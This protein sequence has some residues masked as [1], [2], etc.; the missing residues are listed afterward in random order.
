[1]NQTDKNEEPPAQPHGFACSDFG[2]I[3]YRVHS[4]A[5]PIPYRLTETAPHY[6]DLDQ[7]AR[8]AGL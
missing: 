4:S 6:E 2:T 1:M 7:R 8:E 5:W 3:N